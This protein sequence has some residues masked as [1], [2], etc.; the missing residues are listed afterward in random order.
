MGKKHW[1]SIMMKWNTM[2]YHK[3]TRK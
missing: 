2:K 1:A 3:I